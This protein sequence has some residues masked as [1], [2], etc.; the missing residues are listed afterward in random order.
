MTRAS[1]S[2][3]DM[4]TIDQGSDSDDEEQKDLSP[5]TSTSSLSNRSTSHYNAMI[6]PDRGSKTVSKERCF[7]KIFILKHNSRDD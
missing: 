7:L 4:Y 5:A 6:E 3:A 2:S 1:L